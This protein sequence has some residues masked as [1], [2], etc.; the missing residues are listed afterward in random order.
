MNGTDF[1]AIARMLEQDP[2]SR[3][4]PF[5]QMECMITF[6]VLVLLL[7]RIAERFTGESETVSKTAESAI[8]RESSVN[9]PHTLNLLGV[10]PLDFGPQIN[11]DIMKKNLQKYQWEVVSSWAMGDTLEDLSRTG[12]VEMN[13]VV[14]S[15]G[16]S[17]FEDT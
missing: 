15:V 4:F 5:Q 2:E 13:L 6:M 12:E 17:G 1:P 10:T 8:D 7:Q 16:T 14:S 11:V 3:H 9:Q